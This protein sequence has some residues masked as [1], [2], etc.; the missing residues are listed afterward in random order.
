MHVLINLEHISYITPLVDFVFKLKTC[1]VLDYNS[2]LCK[3]RKV[4]FLLY[5]NIEIHT[6]LSFIDNVLA[7][8]AAIHLLHQLEMMT[9]DDT[10]DQRY[11]EDDYDDDDVDRTRVISDLMQLLLW[12]ELK[13]R[14][15]TSLLYLYLY[16]FTSRTL[17]FP[18]S[19]STHYPRRP[20]TN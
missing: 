6:N 2:T 18:Y 7:L 14:H 19:L 8:C 17:K 1:Q 12:K 20:Q 3:D 10:Y 11:D 15:N 4:V 5:S 9:D 13:L 16:L